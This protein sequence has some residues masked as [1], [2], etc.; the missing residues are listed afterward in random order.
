MVD[1]ITDK[2]TAE[3]AVHTSEERLRLAQQAGKMFAYEWDAATDKIVRSEGVT[4]ILGV[5]AGAHTTG[6]KILAM[7]PPKERTRL[8]AAIAQFESPRSRT[9]ELAIAWYVP[10]GA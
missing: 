2:R 1:D 6:Q 9:F 3:E 7:V 4:Q 8:I 10:R 5:D